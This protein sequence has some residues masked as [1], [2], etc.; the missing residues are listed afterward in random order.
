MP[1]GAASSA[2]TPGRSL[3]R[4]SGALVLTRTRFVSH[5]AHGDAAVDRAAP[6]RH[7]SREPNRFSGIA[8]A[9][10]AAAILLFE[11]GLLFVGVIARYFFHR[12][13]VWARRACLDAV[14]LALGARRGARHA[15]QRAHAA[16][17][18]HRPRGA[19]HAPE[20]R[21]RDPPGR[22][23]V[24]PAHHLSGDRV[25]DR[26]GDRPHAGARHQQLVARVRGRGRR[27]SDRGLLDAAPRSRP[28]RA[29]AFSLASAAIAVLVCVALWFARPLFMG[30]G[31]WN[32]AIFF[33]LGV[34]AAGRC[35]RAD[36]VSRSASRQSAMWRSRR[37]RR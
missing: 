27:G 11:V 25:R 35:R 37:A 23:G 32:L 5:A 7:G 3:E 14:R 34:A 18:L 13:L 19:G 9:L 12:P 15:P 36:R 2:R 21:D 31:N 16:D 1:S 30:L 33:V 17:D 20:D 8:V 22:R 10:V 26:R 4:Y 28:R 24:R 29:R 6:P